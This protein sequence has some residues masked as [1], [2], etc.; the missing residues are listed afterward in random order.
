MSRKKKRKDVRSLALLILVIVVVVQASALVNNQLMSALPTDT[1]LPREPVAA[2]PDV[3]IPLAGYSKADVSVSPSIIYLTT[4]CQQLAM[5]T[6]D[7]QSYSIKNGLEKVVDFRPTTH[8]VVADLADNM[9]I[10]VKLARIDS[11]EDSI[12]YAK[13]FVQQENKVLG[14]ESKPSDAIGVAVRFDAPVY[15]HQTIMTIEGQSIC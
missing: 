6:T 9:D 13:L 7:S 8:D 10:E 11:L 5:V 14:L 15:V 3:S 2:Y 1:I 4:G 12:Y